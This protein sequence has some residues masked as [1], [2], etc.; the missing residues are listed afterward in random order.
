[1]KRLTSVEFSDQDLV[2]SIESF[3][4]RYLLITVSLCHNK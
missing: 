2:Y 3:L 4:M 1:M